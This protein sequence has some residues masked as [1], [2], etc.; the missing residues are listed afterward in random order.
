MPGMEE[1]LISLIYK[2]K[3]ERW[4]LGKYR[5]IAVG[6]ILYRIVS[7]T[8]VI[9]IR[10]LLSTLTD[11]NQKA[12]KEGHLISDNTQLVQDNT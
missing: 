5:P 9:A 3:G 2:N 8:M 6:S 12:F 7:K 10:P 11:E 4:D 1:S